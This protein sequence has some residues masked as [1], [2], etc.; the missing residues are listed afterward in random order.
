MGNCQFMHQLTLMHLPQPL[1]DND[2]KDSNFSMKLQA[3]VKQ[4]EKHAKTEDEYPQMIM[5]KK[6]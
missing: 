4:K 2:G 5:K 6:K 3:H 1:L